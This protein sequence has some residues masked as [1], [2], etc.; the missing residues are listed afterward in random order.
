VKYYHLSQKEALSMPI[1]TADLSC[2]RLVG[3]P[4]CLLPQGEPG[5]A[6]KACLKDYFIKY[7]AN[8]VVTN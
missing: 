7:E 3:S 1:Y 4:T 6:F 2:C 5:V 8:C